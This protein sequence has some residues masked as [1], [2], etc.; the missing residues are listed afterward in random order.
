MY[1]N[2]SFIKKTIRQKTAYVILQ[3][4]K[5]VVNT[6]FMIGADKRIAE[7]IKAILPNGFPG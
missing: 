3:A 1:Y 7:S 5:L 2:G 4:E 6:Y